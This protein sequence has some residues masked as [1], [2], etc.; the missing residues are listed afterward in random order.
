M[1]GEH[2]GVAEQLRFI[3]LSFSDPPRGQAEGGIDEE[4]LEEFEHCVT[5]LRVEAC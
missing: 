1:V 5:A 4:L 3:A 2:D